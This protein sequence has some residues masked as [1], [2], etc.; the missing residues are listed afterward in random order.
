MVIDNKL[1]EIDVVILTGG[2]GTRGA[3]QKSVLK[4]LSQLSW[5]KKYSDSN[6]LPQTAILLWALF[7][8]STSRLLNQ[9][10]LTDN[11][12]R[13]KRLS[14]TCEQYLAMHRQH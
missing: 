9:V 5:Y 3:F 13:L 6:E 14:L 4:I 10:P 1:K 12:L 2:Q 8:I 11:S 7:I